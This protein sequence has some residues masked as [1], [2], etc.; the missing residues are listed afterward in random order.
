MAVGDAAWSAQPLA[1]AGIAKA[2]RDAG[3]AVKV[4]EGGTAEYQQFQTAEFNSYRSQLKQH[5]SL[6]PRWGGSPFWEAAR[7]EQGSLD[8]QEKTF[9]MER[10]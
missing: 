3:S 10:R 5:Y 8:W 2:L 9:G 7:S 4:L 6:E 1:S